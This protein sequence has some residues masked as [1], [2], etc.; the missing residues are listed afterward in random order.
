[1]RKTSLTITFSILSD[2]TQHIALGRAAWA[3]QQLLKA[4][5][6]GCTPITHPGPRWSHYVWLLRG[7]GI[8][9]ETIHEPH[10][11]PFPGTHARYILK[12]E[13]EILSATA[14][15]DAEGMAA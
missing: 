3:L 1:M 13:V 4:G 12:S 14:E 11:G 9:I 2:G 6:K 10:A 5:E 15:P 8:L 7:M